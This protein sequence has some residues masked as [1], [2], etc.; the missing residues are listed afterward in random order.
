MRTGDKFLDT[1]DEKVKLQLVESAPEAAK[2]M[3]KSISEMGVPGSVDL[4]QAWDELCNLYSR[5]LFNDKRTCA[6]I[7]NRRTGTQAFISRDVSERKVS[8]YRHTP[9]L[10]PYWR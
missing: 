7:S 10:L 3:E 2:S 8:F 1:V 4:L 5:D 9:V 6:F